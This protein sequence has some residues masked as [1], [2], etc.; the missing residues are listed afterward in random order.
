MALAPARVHLIPARLSLSPTTCFASGLDDPRGDAESSR[1]EARTAH[2]VA[3]AYEGI[4]CTG[5]PRRR[6][7][8]GSAVRPR[9]CAA[10]RCPARDGAA[11]PRRRLRRFRLRGGP[12]PRRTDVAWRGRRRRFRWRRET[13]RRPDSRS[14]WRRLRGR[15]GGSRCRSL[16]VGFGVAAGGA[17]DGGVVA[18]RTGVAYGP[19]VVIAGFGGPDDGQLDLAGPGRVVGLLSASAFDLGGAHRHAG[20]V[21]PQVHRR[22]GGGRRLGHGAL[23]G[24]D[25]ASQGF[26]GAFDLLGVDRHSSQR[27]QQFVRL[28]EADLGRHQPDHPRGAG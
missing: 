17:L 24:G 10:A 5:G 13:A 7:W 14:S 28:G 9:S 8:R 25:L 20:A 19:A 11:G 15:P 18:D 23:V 3:V 16:A 12:W 4:R 21:Q 2:P 22:R 6:S 27:P 26:G 1:P